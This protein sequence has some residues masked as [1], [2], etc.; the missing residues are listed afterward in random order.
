MGYIESSLMDGEVISYKARL[1]WA[2]ILW[3]VL[4]GV[5]FLGVFAK[6][7]PVL[8]ILPGI[9]LVFALINYFT[10]EFGITNKRLVLKTGVIRRKSHE[11]LIN[12]IERINV[13]QSIV[14]RLLGYGT[15]VV[16]GT[17]GGISPF[18][19]IT[20]PLTFR[21]RI[22]EQISAVEAR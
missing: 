10:S 15:I 11:T 9:W 8:L 12:K 17:G 5:I 19:Y 4:L 3:P 13:H 2:V 22:Q 6:E 1:S 16:S 14:G 7:A 21:K 18:P 20:D